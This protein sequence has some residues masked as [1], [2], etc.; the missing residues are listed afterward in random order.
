M[1]PNIMFYTMNAVDQRNYY[2]TCRICEHEKEGKT[3][4]TKK[5]SLNHIKKHFLHKPEYKNQYFIENENESS[6]SE[7]PE[8][9]AI[10][11][12]LERYI[13]LTIHNKK[14]KDIWEQHKALLKLGNLL[15]WN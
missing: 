5:N 4:M 8:M 9:P 3:L 11:T 14:A 12:P 6:V 2:V 13:G 7:T 15:R 1:N 10:I